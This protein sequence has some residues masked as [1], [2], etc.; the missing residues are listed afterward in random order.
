MDIAEHEGEGYIPLKDIAERQ[1]LSKKYLEII[2]KDLVR[3]NMLTGISGKKGG[4]MLTRRPEEYNLEEILTLMEG[5]LSPVACLAN[6][7]Y[8]CPRK[9]TCKTLPLWTEYDDMIHDF[10]SGKHLSDL[11]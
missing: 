10:F 8:K 1:G 2:A 6:K 7:K 3:G 11:L 4:Y 5:T 9:K